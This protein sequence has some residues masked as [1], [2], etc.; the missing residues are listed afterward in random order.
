MTMMVM[1]FILMALQDS[2]TYVCSAE[3]GLGQSGEADLSLE[4][5][6]AP[7][8]S[9]IPKKEVE[10]GENVW[11]KCNVSSNPRP[12]SIEWIKKDDPSFRQTGDILRIERVSAANVGTYLCKAV[13]IIN[14]SG[15]S[16]TYERTGNASITL[17]IKHAPG[18]SFI[19]PGEPHV[20]EGSGI[21][22]NCGA[23]PP[24]W[25]LPNYR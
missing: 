8:V 24:G 22:L 5:L 14:P 20:V 1:V 9:V 7:I 16:L 25:P 15:D 6:Y 19:E 3:N 10:E 4:V 12:A 2:G 11:I 21:T 17:M 23:N 13:N 18:K